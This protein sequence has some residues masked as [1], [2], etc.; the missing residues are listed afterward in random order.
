MV[1]GK[2]DLLKFLNKKFHHRG[3]EAEDYVA[4]MEFLERERRKEARK[5]YDPKDIY[6][7]KS[8]AKGVNS[9]A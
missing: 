6:C 8:H 4:N 9:Y 3:W 7:K 1:N 2:I 5:N